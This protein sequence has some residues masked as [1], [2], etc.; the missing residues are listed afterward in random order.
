MWRLRYS[1]LQHASLT[2]YTQSAM[3]LPIRFGGMGVGDLAALADAANV[4]A[5]G[6][7]VGSAIRFLTSQDSRVRGDSHDDVPIEPTMY[8][9]LATA[10]FRRPGAPD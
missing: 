9:R 1:D 8:G 6:L 2:R 5:A 3:S 10:V 7:A 4:G